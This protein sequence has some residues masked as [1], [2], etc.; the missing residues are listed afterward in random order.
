MNHISDVFH[1]LDYVGTIAFAVSGSMVAIKKQVDLFG[2]IL[3]GMI[4]A[5]GGGICRDLFLGR[6]PPRI[7]ENK[8]LLF[9]AFLIAVFVFIVAYF[10]RKLYQKSEEK[11]DRINNIFDAVGLGVFTVTGMRVG[12]DEGI[13][14]IV[15]LVFLGCMTGIG[16]GLLRD[17]IVNEIPFVLKKYVYAVAS[18]VGGISYYV[19]LYLQV[20]DQ[21]A[22]VIS[23]SLVFCI[24][25]LATHYRWNL[26]KVN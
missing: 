8:G 24:R 9:I 7:F 4:T 21:L 15:F 12:I 19:L 14:D 1:I 5:V 22:M 25:M 26:P 13:K 16:G 23:V 10:G 20:S 17:L 6:I 2:V 3:L 18:I 11:V